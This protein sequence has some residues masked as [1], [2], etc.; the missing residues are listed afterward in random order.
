MGSQER[1]EDREKAVARFT[2]TDKKTGE[3]NGRGHT[4]GHED[5]EKKSRGRC[6]RKEDR[7]GRSTDSDHRA[8]S[9]S[10]ELRGAVGWSLTVSQ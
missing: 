5:G 4:E 3:N 1:P 2:G 10:A 9:L 6:H 8:G 7:T